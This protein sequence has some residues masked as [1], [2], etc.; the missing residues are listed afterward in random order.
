MSYVSRG[1]NIFTA[2]SLGIILLGFGC[3]LSET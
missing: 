2:I 1:I 3:S